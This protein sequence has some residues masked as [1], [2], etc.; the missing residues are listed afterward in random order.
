MYF[1]NITA[2][3]TEIIKNGLSER[4]ILPYIVWTVLFY[5]VFI[6]L[7]NYIPNEENG[8][9]EYTD[10]ILSLLI[11]VLG[12]LYVYK[13]NAGAEG[14][15]FAAKYFAIGFVVGVRYMFYL[16]IIGI[17][18]IAYWIITDRGLEHHPMTFIEFFILSMLYVL[19]YYSMGKHMHD[20]SL[21]RTEEEIEG[22]K[23]TPTSKLMSIIGIVS[24]VVM[25]I[26]IILGI[27]GES[28]YFPSTKV[29]V[30][31]GVFEKDRQSLI[32]S[33]ILLEE[34]KIEYFYSEGFISILEGGSILTQDRVIGYFQEEDE[35]IDIYELYYN[36]ISSIK[37]IEKG[38]T[39]SNSLYRLNG[40]NE[41]SWLEV[42]LSTEEDGD[43]KFIDMIKLKMKDSEK[44]SKR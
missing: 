19:F 29:E 26:L 14:T 35:T 7:L 15:D 30:G 38:D 39:Y 27:L 8:L 43:I 24:L 42:A 22:L 6:E 13:K 33:G 3:K 1:W 2:L 31:T 10:S 9:W 25:M 4:K 18:L 32:R 36:E 23:V 5:A 28:G 37:L 40:K 11:P 44:N 41:N 12:T 16:M 17:G 21:E 34:D 20:T